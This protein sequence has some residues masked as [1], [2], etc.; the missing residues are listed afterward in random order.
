MNIL[1]NMKLVPQMIKPEA[2]K[3]AKKIIME[4]LAPY[5]E[6]RGLQDIAGNS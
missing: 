6:F 1:H 3:K 2:L 4:S 5:M